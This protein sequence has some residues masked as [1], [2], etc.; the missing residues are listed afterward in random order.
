MRDGISPENRSISKDAAVIRLLGGKG[1]E[2][3]EKGK[4]KGKGKEERSVC[5]CFMGGSLGAG[6]INEVLQGCKTSVLRKFPNVKIIWQTGEKYYQRAIA[7]SPVGTSPGVE[8][9]EL[10]GRL[11][12]VPFL[13]D[14][15]TVYAAC[16]LF[17]CRAGAITCR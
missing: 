17:V 3:E 4:G 5:I 9:E 15:E 7:S 13:H 14:M 1:G 6:K 12:I 16:D 2:K 11:L 8:R 10:R